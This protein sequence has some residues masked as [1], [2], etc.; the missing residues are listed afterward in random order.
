[1]VRV[2]M[3]R[4]EMVGIVNMEISKTTSGPETLETTLGQESNDQVLRVLVRDRVWPDPAPS[5]SGQLT[6]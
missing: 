6:C 4:Y 2:D 3:V 5:V 1:M